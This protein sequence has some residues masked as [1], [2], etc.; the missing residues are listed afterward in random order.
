MTRQTVLSAD[1]K[2]DERNLSLSTRAAVPDELE[3][4]NNAD[5]VTSWE[6][7]SEECANK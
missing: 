6:K 5:M 2:V 1:R 3:A 7:F 4:F